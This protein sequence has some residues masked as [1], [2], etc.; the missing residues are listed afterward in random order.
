MKIAKRYFADVRFLNKNIELMW[1]EVKNI[2]FPILALDNFNK[3][4]LNIVQDSKDELD[5]KLQLATSTGKLAK[6]A[7]IAAIPEDVSEIVQG[8]FNNQRF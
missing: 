1:W 5:K 6:R 8:N 2:D 4:G 3:L 7:V